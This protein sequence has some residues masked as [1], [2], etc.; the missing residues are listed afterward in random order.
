MC[1]RIHWHAETFV[2]ENTDSV[3]GWEYAFLSPFL[4]SSL[5]AV[6]ISSNHLSDKQHTKQWRQKNLPK[7]RQKLCRSEKVAKK[8]R[9]KNGWRKLNPP[10]FDPTE[11]KGKRQA[12]G[13]DDA[14]LQGARHVSLH[15]HYIVCHHIWIPTLLIKHV[16]FPT[17]WKRRISM[18]VQEL[19]LN[20]HISSET[21]SFSYSHLKT[22]PNQIP[23]KTLNPT[24]WQTLNPA[25]AQQ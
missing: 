4:S 15:L 5:I 3:D 10:E 2:Q 23:S 6:R 21:N 16:S 19:P 8:K 25:Q 20:Q 7:A 12:E 13:F 24:Q 22:Q 11:I 9:K 14:F 18:E 1:S 17:G